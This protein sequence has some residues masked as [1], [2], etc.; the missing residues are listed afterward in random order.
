MVDTEQPEGEPQGRHVTYCGGELPSMNIN[1]DS[2]ANL[3][4]QQ[5]V[6]YPPRYAT[7]PPLFVLRLEA[8]W[9]PSS[10]ASMAAQLGNAKNGSK[11]TSPLCM[12]K[13][14]LQVYHSRPTM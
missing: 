14:G 13:F 3:K 7:V 5:F 10:I 1:C 2:A 6:H 8:E 11:R 9:F 4:F 12:I